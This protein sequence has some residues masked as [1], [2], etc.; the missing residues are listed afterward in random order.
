MSTPLQ[1]QRGKDDLSS[2][3]GLIGLRS[4][5]NK[6]KTKKVLNN[7][8]ST[9]RRSDAISDHDILMAM[10]GIIATGRSDFEAIKLFAQDTVFRSGLNLKRVPSPETLRQRFDEFPPRVHQ[11]LQQVNLAILKDSSLGT[12]ALGEQEFVPLDADVSILENSCAQ[13]REGVSFTYKRCN[14]YAPKFAYL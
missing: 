1:I 12:V 3:A 11:A 2:N 7:L 8:F 9:Q 14:G 6:A 13:K 10:V 4:Q 5:F